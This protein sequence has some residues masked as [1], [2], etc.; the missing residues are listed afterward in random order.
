MFVFDIDAEKEIDDILKFLESYKESGCR[1]VVLGL[2]GGKDSTVVA[3]LAKKV[4]GDDALAILMPNGEQKDLSDSLAIATQ[5]GI[6]YKVVDIETIYS[7]LIHAVENQLIDVPVT[8]FSGKEVFERDY[9]QNYHPITVKARTN[10]P[11]R[12]RMTILYAVAQTMGYR[13]M[14]TGNLSEYTIGW[15]T[16]WG[17]GAYDVNPI[18]HLTCTEVVKI[19]KVLAKEFNL[20]VKYI[21]KTPDDGL[22]GK[23]DEENFGFSYEDLDNYIRNYAVLSPALASKINQ[24]VGYSEHKKNPPVKIHRY[25]FE[26]LRVEDDK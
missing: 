8:S 15:F 23:S 16:K 25:S 22:S 10:I 5:I 17:D 24:M 13:V 1:G 7:S 21:T 6:N 19:G 3:M 18:G 20:D 12:I 2:S 26:V 4:W 11:P 14:G 9:V